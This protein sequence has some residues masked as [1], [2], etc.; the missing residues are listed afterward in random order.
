MTPEEIQQVHKA[1]EGALPVLRLWKRKY[2]VERRDLFDAIR[3]VERYLP[4]ER[5]TDDTANLPG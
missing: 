4:S 3:V 2:Y 1:L 5:E